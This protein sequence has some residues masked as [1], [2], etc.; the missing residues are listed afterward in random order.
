MKS[1]SSSSFQ[2]IRSHFSFALPQCKQTCGS[3][4]LL[5]SEEELTFRGGGEK[6]VGGDGA[7]E[8]RAPPSPWALPAPCRLQPCRQPSGCWLQFAD[9][10][11]KARE[12]CALSRGHWQ[13]AHRRVN[14]GTDPRCARCPRC[15][16]SHLLC[17]PVFKH[18]SRV[19]GR[20]L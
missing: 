19:C 15:G 4:V 2:K 12:G 9:E 1:L 20:G 6:G 5:P 3:P 8:Q 18:P 11:S 7:P 17:L 10:K 13:P 16:L 14:R